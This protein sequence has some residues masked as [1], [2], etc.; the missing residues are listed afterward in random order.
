MNQNGFAQR[1]KKLRSEQGLSQCELAEALKIS[2]SCINN[3]EL[4]DSKPTVDGLVEV[5]RYFRVSIDYLVGL[6]E[7]T[8]IHVTH[9]SSRA[10]EAVTNLI[11]VME[12]E[13]EAGDK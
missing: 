7:R 13:S 10:I 5:A 8:V 11:R 6:D 3:W 9:L 2:R 12:T 4:G 1:L